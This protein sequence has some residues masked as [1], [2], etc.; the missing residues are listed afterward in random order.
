[1]ISLQ[2]P[3]SQTTDLIGVGQKLCLFPP[4]HRYAAKG[5]YPRIGTVIS[6]FWLLAINNICPIN[7]T[8]TGCARYARNYL[9]T[10]SHGVHRPTN[11]AIF[12]LTESIYLI[13]SAANEYASTFVR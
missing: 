9:S 6:I 7:R 5:I 11:S 1:M 8:Y 3:E 13:Q 12:H 4:F 2:G 10:A